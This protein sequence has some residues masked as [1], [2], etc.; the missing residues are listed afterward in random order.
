MPKGLEE[1]IGR[2]KTARTA[3]KTL[4]TSTRSSCMRAFWFLI[5][6]SLF[7]SAAAGSSQQE[8][9]AEQVQ[10][11]QQAQQPQQPQQEAPPRF[12]AEVSAVLVDVLVLDGQGEPMAGLTREDFQVLEDGV[13]QEIDSFEVIDWTSYVARVAP[14]GETAAPQP[15]PAAAVNAFP[16]RFV[17]II[18]R[19]SASTP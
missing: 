15:G 10:Q 2:D 3:R 4:K 12:R 5:A 17:F 1:V 14:Q 6:L 9:Q 18:N 7:L 16:R 13:R 19:Q 8:R 11:T